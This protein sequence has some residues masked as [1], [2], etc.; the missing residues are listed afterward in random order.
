MV[1]HKSP[2]PSKRAKLARSFQGDSSGLADQIADLAINA[3]QR[4]AISE[5]IEATK[6]PIIVAIETLQECQW[7]I[8]EAISRFGED[9]EEEVVDTDPAAPII[10]PIRS[11]SPSRSRNPSE[12]IEHIRSRSPSR[13]RKSIEDSDFHLRNA[14]HRATIKQGHNHPLCFHSALVKPIAIEY[15][16]TG[17]SV[18]VPLFTSPYEEKLWYTGFMKP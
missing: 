12:D 9:A 6:E 2:P 13:S 3:E 8:L 4:T 17:R 16:S 11:R 14:L 7:D 5:F 1:D 15:S 18:R 10:E